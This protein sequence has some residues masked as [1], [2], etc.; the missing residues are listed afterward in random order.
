MLIE[1]VQVN[2]FTVYQKIT[3]NSVSLDSSTDKK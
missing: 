1:K 3:A 2:V